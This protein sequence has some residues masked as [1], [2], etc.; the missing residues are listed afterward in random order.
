MSRTTVALFFGGQSAEHEISIISAQSIAAHLDTER[1]TLLPIYITHS[2]EWLCDGFARTLLTT[3]LASKL[4]G[5]SREETAAALQQMVRNAAQA[6]CNRNLAALGVD[7]A[8]LALHGSFGEDGRMQGFLETCGIPYTGCGVLASAL[9]MD[10]ALT[11][12]CVADAGIA[13]A[14]GTNILSADYLANPN[15]VEASV[16]AQVSYPLFVKPASLGSSIGISKVHNREE[17]HPALQAACALDWKVVVESTVKGRE[18]EVAVLGNADPI[19]SV[20][21][22]IEPGKEF[23]D[24]QDKYMGNSAKLFIPARIPESLQEEVRRS[25]LTAYRALGCSGMAR[26]D[27]F[28]DEST[29]S[30]VL[31]EVNTIPGFTDISMYPQ[32]MEASGISYRNLITRLLELALEPLRR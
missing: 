29:N 25:A 15:A 5:S 21:G 26:V 30:V 31:N 11:K 28:V 18:I 8:F 14:Q 20:C 19:A 13:V 17:L 6:P 9:T 10:K 24:F 32:M 23:Y 27:F 16:E 1:F 22:E 7:V 4:R 3:N 12:L 2:G